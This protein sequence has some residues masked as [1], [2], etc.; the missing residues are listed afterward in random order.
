MEFSR[1]NVYFS[2]KFTFVFVA[3]NNVFRMMELGFYFQLQATNTRIPNPVYARKVPV[4]IPKLDK[5]RNLIINREAK[6]ID[7]QLLHDEFYDINMEDCYDGYETRKFTMEER[8]VFC[9][10]YNVFVIETKY[11][12]LLK[13]KSVLI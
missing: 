2:L 4:H 10:S 3:Q 1:R 9:S 6:H 11:I 8:N 12:Y 5:N 13:V 7:V